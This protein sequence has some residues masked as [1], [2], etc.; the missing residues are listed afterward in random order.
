MHISAYVNY[1]LEPRGKCKHKY[2][3]FKQNRYGLIVSFMFFIM[4][5]KLLL[6]CYNIPHISFN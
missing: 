2:I 5:Q 6:I 3:P 4:S 1:I